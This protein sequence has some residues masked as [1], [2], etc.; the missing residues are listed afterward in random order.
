VVIGARLAHDVTLVEGQV[1]LLEDL[2]QL[3][4]PET[5]AA[6]GTHAR[7]GPHDADGQDVIAN[8]PKLPILT[9][10][11]LGVAGVGD[12]VRAAAG[13]RDGVEAA[14]VASGDLLEATLGEGEGPEFAGVEGTGFG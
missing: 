11:G 5:T 14:A 1:I 12:L 6:A 4:M 8:M 3:P 13:S 7:L 2:D 9:G 10:A